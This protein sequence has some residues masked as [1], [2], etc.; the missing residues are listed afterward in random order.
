MLCCFNDPEA[1][2]KHASLI[3]GHE[4]Y[5]DACKCIFSVSSTNAQM[6]KISAFLKTDLLTITIDKNLGKALILIFETRENFFFHNY[7][8][9]DQRRCD[10]R[11]NSCH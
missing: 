10:V 8:V 9:M 7:K 6:K 2:K 3:N 4:R 5:C 1:G 11:G